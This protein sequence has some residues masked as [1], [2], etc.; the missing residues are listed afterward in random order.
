MTL[1]QHVFL[2]WIPLKSSR[3]FNGCNRYFIGFKQDKT[4]ILSSQTTTILKII[5]NSATYKKLFSSPR[6]LNEDEKHQLNDPSYQDISQISAPPL[7]PIDKFART[8]SR[9]GGKIVSTPLPLNRDQYDDWSS[10]P[11][12][13]STFRATDN[14]DRTETIP[15]KYL[16]AEKRFRNNNILVQPIKDSFREKSKP[17]VAPVT[18]CVQIRVTYHLGN[19]QWK[20]NKDTTFRVCGSDVQ[21]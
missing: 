3:H 4:P 11:N 5:F 2:S 7:E 19:K 18:T 8:A 20:E 17:I 1:D 15:A 10:P 13:L 12:P 6:V 14:P 21:V 16:R 9:S